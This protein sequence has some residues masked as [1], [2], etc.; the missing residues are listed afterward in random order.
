M[1]FALDLPP[2]A[3]ARDPL[4]VHRGVLW[5]LEMQ[6]GGFGVAPS[7]PVIAAAMHWRHWQTA[8]SVLED[9]HRRCLIQW[10][11]RKAQ[12]IKITKHGRRFL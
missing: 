10:D 1:T 5:L 8:T 4:P 11:G 9:M 6:I 2:P 7:L 12:S 3:T